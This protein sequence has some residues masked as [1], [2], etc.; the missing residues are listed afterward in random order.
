VRRRRALQALAAAR[1]VLSEHQPQTARPV[2]AAGLLRVPRR[3]PAAG[4]DLSRLHHPRDAQAPPAARLLPAQ[5]LLLLLLPHDL[6]AL[7]A[8]GRPVLS[9]RLR[10]AGQ[11]G[12]RGAAEGAGLPPAGRQH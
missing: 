9:G 2:A 11:P 4:P 6:A 3:R 7:H 12:S 10:G 1:L 8:D 5:Q